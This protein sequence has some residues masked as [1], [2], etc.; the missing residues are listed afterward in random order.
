MSFFKNYAEIEAKKLLPDPFFL[1]KAL[2]EA[3]AKRLQLSFY[4]F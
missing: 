1:K 4:I 2:N 3:K